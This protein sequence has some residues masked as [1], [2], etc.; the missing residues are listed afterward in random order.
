MIEEHGYFVWVNREFSDVRGNH[1]S[2][3]I[4]SLLLSSY[5]LG[6]R[7]PKKWW[8]Y[9]RHWLEREIEIQFFRDGVNF[10]KSGG[11]H[12]LVLELFL[13]AAI[14]LWHKGEKLRGDLLERLENAAFFSDS[15][16]RPDGLAT[17]FGDN[18]NAV[19]LPF[20]FERS[21]SHG[22]VIELARAWLGSAI[23]SCVFDE[24]DAIAPQFLIGNRG[25]I[26]LVLNDFEVINFSSGGFAVV[27]N[28]ANGFF[29]MIDI[30]EVGMNGRGGHG[31]NDLLSF[32]LFINGS[33]VVLDPGCSGYTSDLTKKDLYRSTSAHATVQLFDSEMARFFGP[34]GIEDDARPI[35]VSVKRTSCG[36]DITAGHLGYSRL[37]NGTEVKRNF[38]VDA[39]RQVLK[40][41]DS[42][43]V[44]EGQTKSRWHFPLG[45]ERKLILQNNIVG[46]EAPDILITI[47]VDLR[48]DTKLAPFSSGYGQEQ[49][50]NVLVAETI[51]SKGTHE[52]EFQ[53]QKQ[54]V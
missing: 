50:G 42:I 54:A 6:S 16:T 25:P 29:C 28:P 3:N 51:L 7:A 47:D 31:H 18:D 15:I 5:S 23:G 10:E 26:P 45:P 53:F 1:F 9:A 35:K 34:W 40:I 36:A 48:L 38:H 33:A 27:R 39:K 41:T 8:R 4:I 13:L 44:P 46:L 17:N 20:M 32:E 2:A 21:K 52:F 49:D 11:Y 37:V 12:K 30:G 22:S 24:L 14:A 19:A 43:C